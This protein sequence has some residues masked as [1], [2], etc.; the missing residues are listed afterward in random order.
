VIYLKVAHVEDNDCDIFSFSNIH[1]AL[2]YILS[3]QLND[4]IMS[5]MAFEEF[6]IE[7]YTY[8]SS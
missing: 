6:P 5:D 2:R 4:W 7:D 8:I 1:T 3:E